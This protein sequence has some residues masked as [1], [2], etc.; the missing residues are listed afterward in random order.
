M[1]HVKCDTSNK[2]G[3]WNPLRIIQKLF[4][5]HT[6]KARIQGTTEN[7]HNGHCT[8]TLDSTNVKALETVLQ[9]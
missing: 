4:E 8:H 2:V 5:Q 1:W 3:D 6:R 7:S 9:A